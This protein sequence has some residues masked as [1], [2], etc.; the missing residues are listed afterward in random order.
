MDNMQDK[1]SKAIIQRY[2]QQAEASLMDNGFWL[3]V[4]QTR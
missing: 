3:T 1:A 4:F 2:A